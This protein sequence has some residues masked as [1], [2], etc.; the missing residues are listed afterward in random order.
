VAVLVELEA[1]RITRAAVSLAHRVVEIL[2]MEPALHAVAI[3]IPIG[4][5]EQP[6]PGGRLCDREARRVLGRT[7]AALSSIL[8]SGSSHLRR[9]MGD[10]GPKE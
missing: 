4:L 2:A 5:L 1:S 9:P 7:R 6:E 3:D 10:L 8:L